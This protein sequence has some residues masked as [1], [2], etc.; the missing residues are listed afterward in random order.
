MLEIRGGG[1]SQ[2]VSKDFETKSLTK[3]PI[4]AN[5]RFRVCFR[6]PCAKRD[7]NPKKVAR[8][9]GKRRVKRCDQNGLAGGALEVESARLAQARRNFCNL[10]SKSFETFRLKAIL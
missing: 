6:V 3:N 10:V 2:L 8:S 4:C 7:G 1:V 9:L 5:A